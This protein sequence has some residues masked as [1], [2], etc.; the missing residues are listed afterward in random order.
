MGWH[1]GRHEPVRLDSSSLEIEA[2]AAVKSEQEKIER[3]NGIAVEIARIERSFQQFPVELRMPEGEYDVSS[4]CCHHYIS[5]RAKA[6]M[7]GSSLFTLIQIKSDYRTADQHALYVPQ[8]GRLVYDRKPIAVD[9]HAINQ[10]YHRKRE[11]L[12]LEGQEALA[13]E[14]EILPI[15]TKMAD[16]LEHQVANGWPDA[17]DR[18]RLEMAFQSKSVY[19]A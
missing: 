19:A 12:H 14:P 7:L 1:I 8:D 13:A 18:M 15:I 3:L 4:V 10:P 6:A 11:L 5:E 9:G 16:G 2:E 17:P